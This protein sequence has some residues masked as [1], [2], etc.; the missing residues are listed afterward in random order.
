MYA[1]QHITK[2]QSDSLGELNVRHKL[3]DHWEAIQKSNRFAHFVEMISQRG[4]N[5]EIDGTAITDDLKELNEFIQEG[6][7]GAP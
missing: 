3:N 5:Y 2:E 6:Y 7:F 1:P 4:A